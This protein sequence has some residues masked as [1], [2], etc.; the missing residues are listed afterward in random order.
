M[1][2]AFSLPGTFNTGTTTYLDSDV[3]FDSFDIELD[4]IRYCTSEITFNVSES[5][6]DSQ[7]GV[8]KPVSATFTGVAHT[9]PLTNGLP[10]DTLIFTGSFCLNGII[11][12]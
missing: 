4:T 10:T 2:L 8:Y 5:N 12:Q 1:S 11:M 6:L 7:D 9:Y 3:N